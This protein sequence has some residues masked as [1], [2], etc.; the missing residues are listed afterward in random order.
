VL[1]HAK[2]QYDR[3]VNDDV[4]ALREPIDDADFDDPLYLDQLWL[5]Q[6]LFELE[7]GQFTDVI[8]TAGGFHILKMVE[9]KAA[10]N[11]TLD[12]QALAS[13]GVHVPGGQASFS[14]V[15]HDLRL[16]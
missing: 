13:L 12:T 3:S 8:E 1:L 10:G 15:I 6:A 14:F 9:Y 7:P 16:E 11:A 5:E 4:G 2:G